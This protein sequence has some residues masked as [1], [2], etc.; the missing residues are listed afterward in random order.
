MR[1]WRLTDFKGWPPGISDGLASPC[2]KCGTRPTFDFQID[3]EAWSAIVPREMRSG[4]VCPPCLDAMA[5]EVGMDVN[6]HVREVQFSGRHSTLV[7]LP[8]FT[9]GTVK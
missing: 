7:L 4:V 6:E 8:G 9:V 2:L 1:F 3:D 5:S